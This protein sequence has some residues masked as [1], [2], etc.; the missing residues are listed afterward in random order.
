MP[1]CRDAPARRDA[2]ND[3][4]GLH[5]IAFDEASGTLL[6]TGQSWP[7]TF[8]VQRPPWSR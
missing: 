4:D 1:R 8:T 3:A 7:L 2:A 5:G 6:L